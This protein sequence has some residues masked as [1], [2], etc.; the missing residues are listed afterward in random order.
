MAKILK[1]LNQSQL[2]S[3]IPKAKQFKEDKKNLRKNVER[4]IKSRVPVD[5]GRLRNTTRSE[6]TK[7]GFLVSV[8]DYATDYATAV[9]VGVKARTIK[10]V[11]PPNLTKK[12]TVGKGFLAFQVGG[13]WIRTQQVKQKRRKGVFFVRD[14]A[15]MFFK[16]VK[17]R[18]NV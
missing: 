14:G 6:N 8:G 13:R 11:Q 10:A 5:S 1:R 2:K 15:K 3:Q 12:G 17:R 18:K 4:E 16:K 7:D 9:E